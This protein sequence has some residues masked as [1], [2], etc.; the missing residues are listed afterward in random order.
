MQRLDED[1]A[2]ELAEFY[3]S[4]VVADG[5]GGIR[6][7]TYLSELGKIWGY[8]ESDLAGNLDIDTNRKREAVI[9]NSC[10]LFTD[11]GLNFSIVM[12]GEA[13][14]PFFGRSDVRNDLG[15]TLASRTAFA[16]IWRDTEPDEN[17]KYPFFVQ[18]FKIFDE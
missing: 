10:G 1:Q 18:Y 5:S 8:D 15:T 7:L 16:Q 9:R 17:G 11:R 4:S 14:T 6:T 3:R 2:F 13:Y 12:R